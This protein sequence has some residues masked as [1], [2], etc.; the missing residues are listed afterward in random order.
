MAD[1]WQGR[2]IARKGNHFYTGKVQHEKHF[3][4]FPAQPRRHPLHGVSRI[5]YYNNNIAK[6]SRGLSR[7]KI[8]G[9]GTRKRKANDVDATRNL[10][11]DAR[12]WFHFYRMELG[13]HF[14]LT[15]FL[16]YLLSYPIVMV[17][18]NNRFLG[19]ISMTRTVYY[20]KFVQRDL[21]LKKKSPL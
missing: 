20:I 17:D 2:K 12:R 19:L 1:V 7:T 10:V 8:W 4:P 9:K 21:T 13:E 16:R 11:W 6:Q 15:P 3:P 14:A 18:P 5:L